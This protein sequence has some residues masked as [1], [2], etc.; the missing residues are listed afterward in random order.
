[1]RYLAKQIETIKFAREGVIQVKGKE[2]GYLSYPEAFK[3]FGFSQA[4]LYG[5][6]DKDC[7]YLN[8][9]KLDGHKEMRLVDKGNGLREVRVYNL[10]QLERIAQ[11]RQREKSGIFEDDQGV[12]LS[13]GAALRMY[14]IWDASLGD[15]RTD[16]CP[17]LGRTVKWKRVRRLLRN[18][19][20][21][22]RFVYL[23]SDVEKIAAAQVASAAPATYRDAQGTWLFASEVSRRTGWPADGLWYY[24]KKKWPCLPSGKIRAKTVSSKHH[25]HYPR[26]GRSQAWVYHEGDIE[27]VAAYRRGEELPLLGE[28]ANGDTSPS[29]SQPIPNASETPIPRRNN[30]GG[31]PSDTAAAVKKF[32]YE[33]YIKGDKLAK[34]RS[35]ATNVFGEKAA[36]KQDGHVTMYA[37]RYAEKHGLPCERPDA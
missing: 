31:R 22:T 20:Y 34:I 4:S 12:W 8:G 21:Q 28:S 17:Y 32:C 33:R 11:A 37:K 19:R 24:R 14:K 3:R 18:G 10:R 13:A 7:C 1:V 26:L 6:H 9:E 15:W 16:P 2:K 29:I 36:P 23:E 5:W 27:R 25:P 35:E 30:V